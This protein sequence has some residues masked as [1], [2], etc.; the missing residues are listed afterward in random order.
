MK[1]ITLLLFSLLVCLYS[2]AQQN[3]FFPG[4]NAYFSVSWM[5]FHFQGDT[6]IDNFKYK[7]VYMQVHDS[8]ADFNKAYYFAAIREDTVAE[9]IYCLFH[10]YGITGERLLYD[11]SV[12]VG[13]VVNFFT[14][15]GEAGEK[16]QVVESIDSILIDN[17]YRKRINFVNYY[18]DTPNDSW[19]EGIG[20]TQGLFFAGPFDMVDGMDW[21]Y[22]LCVHID[23]E[24]IYQ[25]PD[26][27][28]NN[29]YIREYGVG[30]IENKNETIKIYP[31]FADNALYIETYRDI[32]NFE[33]KIINIQGQ[34][35]NSGIF[36]SNTINI[37]N[38]DKGLYLIM[39]ADNKSKK[40]ITTQKFIKR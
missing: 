32:E 5:K 37:S 3:Y 31:T 40:S 6:I 21:T 33:Y 27:L 4:S 26:I 15:W 36:T 8:I 34:I 10:N 38:L 13:D 28:N 25:N 2:F 22:L 11:F 7:K 16:T 39:I 30:I 24:L 20:S 23:G 14:L 35:M 18:S 1:K 29:C 19:I 9:K 12:N 17:H